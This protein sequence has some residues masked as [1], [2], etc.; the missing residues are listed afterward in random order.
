MIAIVPLSLIDSESC[1][2]TVNHPWSSDPFFLCW[3]P[4][5]LPRGRCAPPTSFARPYP[6][7]R[8]INGLIPSPDPPTPTKKSPPQRE[9]L[10]ASAPARCRRM[11]LRHSLA[12]RRS[13]AARTRAGGA[14][15]PARR[16]ASDPRRWP[17]Q[18]LAPSRR[19]TP[20]RRPSTPPLP[21]S[22][23]LLTRPC[24]RPRNSTPGSRMAGERNRSERIKMPKRR[25]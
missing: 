1:S 18:R 14:R 21:L 11:A 23:P 12:V 9:A 13:A 20:L 16:G 10:G 5:T 15:L 17:L 24:S 8:P 22:F 19:P 3:M 6:F 7:P 25:G 4:A 2:S